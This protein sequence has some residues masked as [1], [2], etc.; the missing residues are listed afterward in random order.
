M[1]GRM[2][3]EVLKY[4]P[5]DLNLLDRFVLVALAEVARDTDRTARRGASTEELADKLQ[6]T[7]G[8]I[9]NALMRLRERALIVPLYAHPRKG[10]VQ[11]YR[12][13][14]L[15]EGTRKASF[16]G[17]AHNGYKRH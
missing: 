8:S 9:R 11:N 7:P 4:A 14:T 3:G 13:A 1:S 12:I 6:S 2:V 5:H 10:L 15:N 17:D 16:T